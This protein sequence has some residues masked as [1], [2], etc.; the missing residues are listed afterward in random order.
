MGR[1]L[2][3][4]RE[5]A[6]WWTVTGLLPLAYASSY[7]AIG[8]TPVE[9]CSGAPA[10]ERVGVTYLSAPVE[11]ANVGRDGFFPFY[12]STASTT[13]E[14]ALA[15]ITVEVRDGS[16][17]LVPGETV[18]ISE[19][20]DDDD[21]SR[22]TLGW[23]AT[24]SAA[25]DGEVLT[26]HAS[27]TNTSEP[28]TLDAT[29]TVV[30]VEPELTLPSFEVSG[31]T[32]ARHDGGARVDCYAFD[33][34]SNPFDFGAEFLNRLHMKVDVGPLI[35]EVMVLWEFDWLPV[36]GKGALLSD[37]SPFEPRNG[38]SSRLVFEQEEEELCLRL[39]GRDLHT[40]DTTERELCASPSGEIEER[41]Y[42]SVRECEEPPPGYLE[43]WCLATE[44]EDLG[45]HAEECE[46][47]LNP[48]TGTGGSDGSGSGGTSEP[49]TGGTGGGA[50]GGGGR[51]TGTGAVA[52]STGTGEPP[53]AG[54]SGSGDE[55]SG[56]GG[57][58]S[59]GSSSDGEEVDHDTVV[60]KPVLTEGGCGCRAAGGGGADSWL[61]GAGLV[62]LAL[63]LGLRRRRERRA[64]P[65]PR[66]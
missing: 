9:G 62:G 10:E 5:R 24:G 54:S 51:A 14:D 21:T 36:S 26:F 39:R 28:V 34:C 66:S 57:P 33:S 17:E 60:S 63:G 53:A 7:V 3:R 52:G 25:A 38:F 4:A 65:A 48:S 23:S 50:T 40:G 30:D 58:A 1:T 13:A 59:A 29:L 43:R 37:S 64:A 49:G 19:A 42:D 31:W 55:P 18:L 46:P 12:A 56:D 20:P 22:L 16:G 44:K 47:Y 35:P 11:E 8:P 41:T 2:G 27:A 45:S 32:R 15:D 61:G 6:F